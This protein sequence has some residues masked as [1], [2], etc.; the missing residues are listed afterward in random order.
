M[1]RVAKARLAGE[2]LLA[3]ATARWHLS[4]QPLPEAVNRLR[5]VERSQTNA[6]GRAQS[7][8]LGRAVTRTLSPLPADTRC[9]LRSL[10]LVRVLARRGGRPA[11]VIAARPGERTELDAHAWVEVEGQPVLPPASSDYGRLVTL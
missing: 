3:Y 8:R 7:A 1:S 4:R 6:P 5:G 11:L 10:V 9:L 2:I